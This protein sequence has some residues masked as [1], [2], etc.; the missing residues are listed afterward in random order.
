MRH[1]ERLKGR[2]TQA[3]SFSILVSILVCTQQKSLTLSIFQPLVTCVFSSAGIVIHI[4]LCYKDRY[5]DECDY[6][7]LCRTLKGDFVS[8]KPTPKLHDISDVIICTILSAQVQLNWNRQ[9]A[10]ACVRIAYCAIKKV[11]GYNSFRSRSSYD[12][13]LSLCA[14]LIWF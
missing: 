13:T 7:K 3:T 14:F 11:A 6:H 1:S 12:M 5:F 4:I 2:K 8:L 9:E 10:A